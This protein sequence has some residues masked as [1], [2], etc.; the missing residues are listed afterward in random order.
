MKNTLKNMTNYEKKMAE[1]RKYYEETSISETASE[2]EEN[3]GGLDK[4]NKVLLES[5]LSCSDL[6][7]DQNA[8][9]QEMMLENQ[10]S[11]NAVRGLA[12]NLVNHPE[13][14]R[15]VN[16]IQS[17]RGKAEY[18]FH[19]VP[20][21]NIELRNNME[22]LLQEAEHWSVQHAELSE[23][24]RLYQKSQNDI[25]VA[26]E[27]KGVHFQTQ[28]NNKVSVNCELEEQV[29]KLKHDT[30]SLRLILALL[31]NE[32]QILQQRVELLKKLYHLKDATQEKPIPMTYVQDKKE[33]RLLEAQKVERYKQKMQGLEGTFQNRIKSRRGLDSCRSRKARN[34]RFNTCLARALLGR[35]RLAI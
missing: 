19:H 2:F 15:A 3:I 29:R 31:E 20:E 30:Y 23:L 18:R 35:K 22:Q 17:S 7:E 13:V 24:I 11:K 9:K 6:D 32:C 28:L 16:E 27:H 34:N 8:M 25:R 12:R 10:Y 5:L 33:Q 4:I 26:L 14:K 1:T 21:E